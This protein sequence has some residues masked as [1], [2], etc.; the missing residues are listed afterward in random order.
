MVTGPVTAVTPVAAAT[1]TNALSAKSSLCSA[2]RFAALG[3]VASGTAAGGF[4]SSWG[5]LHPLS[6]ATPAN[7]D[8]QSYWDNAATVNQVNSLDQLTDT[9][10][11]NINFGTQDGCIT[12]THA[13][14]IRNSILPDELAFAFWG[15]GFSFNLYSLGYLQKCGCT[16]KTDPR[17]P[18]PPPPG[19][20]ESMEVVSAGRHGHQNQHMRHLGMQLCPSMKRVSPLV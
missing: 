20:S 13:G 3:S 14:W 16:Y 2:N 10:P 15:P 1:S 19:H 12:A 17:R 8:D 6:H 11:V 7:N 9:E 5:I 4:Q 18:H